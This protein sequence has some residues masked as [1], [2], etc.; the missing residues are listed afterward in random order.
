MVDAM[1]RSPFDELTLPHVHG[2]VRADV[3][4]HHTRIELRG[5]AGTLAAAC[6]HLGIEGGDAIAVWSAT[7]QRVLRGPGGQVLILGPEEALLVCDDPASTCLARLQDFGALSAVDVSHRDA[8]LSLGGARV[9][10]V[11]SAGCPLD[12]VAMPVGYAT[13]TLLG[14]AEIVLWRQATGFRLSCRRSLALYVAR[15]L[16]EATREY[17]VSST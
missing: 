17:E 13:R 7:R 15:F 8:T 12:L 10:D 6:A 16:C 1:M 4:S 2:V 9:E 3:I 5:R 14:K 11:L